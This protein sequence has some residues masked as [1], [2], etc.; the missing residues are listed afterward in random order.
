M[1]ALWSFAGVYF[2]KA[3]AQLAIRPEEGRLL[4]VDGAV[5]TVVPDHPDHAEPALD[6]RVA[7]VGGDSAKTRSGTYTNPRMM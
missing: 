2:P 5:T 1:S 4:A 3:G 6:G 7:D